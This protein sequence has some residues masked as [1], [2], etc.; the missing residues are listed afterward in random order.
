MVK[1]KQ[2]LQALKEARAILYGTLAIE[3][4]DGVSTPLWYLDRELI[5]DTLDILGS[6]GF[7]IRQ[8][9]V[10]ICN[11]LTKMKIAVEKGPNEMVAK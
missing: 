3:V 7:T 4:V 10:A 2:R 5:G 1:K 6:A 11:I 9:Y 8:S